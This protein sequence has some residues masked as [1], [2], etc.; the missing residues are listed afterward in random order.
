[1]RELLDRIPRWLKQAI[2]F[3]LVGVSNT[4]ID[5]GLY[6]LLTRYVGFFAP[7]K[8]AAKALSYT[9]GV[10]NSFFWNR[11]WTF[12]SRANPWRTFA[13]FFLSNLIGVG[14]NSGVMFVGLSILQLPELLSFAL[15]TGITIGWNFLISK[16]VVFK[17]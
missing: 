15:A 6:F 8:V 13:P 1:M 2:K 5:A 9:A 14:I 7:R 11:N 10:V 17:A 12:R 16:F 3:V 4:A